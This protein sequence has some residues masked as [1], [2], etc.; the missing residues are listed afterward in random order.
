MFIIFIDEIIFLYGLYLELNINV[1]SGVFGLL[2]GV[3]I[4]L[5]IFLSIF[6]I[7]ILDLVFVK[8]ILF[9]FK[10]IIFLI[11]CF[12]CL[13]FVVGKLILLII[14]NNFNLLFNV[15]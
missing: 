8:I 4:I 1:F 10:F 13:G 3:G 12:M 5:I 9:W 11:F 7:L 14:G 2:F 15:K 6:L